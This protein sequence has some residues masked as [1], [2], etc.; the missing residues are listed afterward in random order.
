MARLSV[1]VMRV[2]AGV[3]GLVL[4]SLSVGGLLVR[5]FVVRGLMV[6]VNRH[7]VIWS[8]VV[9]RCGV[10]GVK[11]L[12]E[13]IVL[14]EIVYWRLSLLLLWMNLRLTSRP[15]G[16]RWVAWL[17]DRLG[18]GLWLR[19]RYSIL[20]YLFRDCRRLLGLSRSTIKVTA[21]TF[22]ETLLGLLS[23]DLLA[24]GSPLCQSQ[25]SLFVCKIILEL[26]L[27]HLLFIVVIIGVFSGLTEL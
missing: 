27:E 25:F 4:S 23:P 26:L 7:V 18:L 15:L 21:A 2:L 11:C 3:R 22:L 13:V 16:W 8:V 17:L 9:P 12:V 19:L 14:V 20:R 5:D 1:V 6:M 24:F 10:V